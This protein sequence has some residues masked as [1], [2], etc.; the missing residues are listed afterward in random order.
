MS[1]YHGCIGQRPMGR[2]QIA[3][4]GALTLVGLAG[5][6]FR[7]IRPSYS[8]VGPVPGVGDSAGFDAALFQTTGAHLRGGHRWWL[9][10]DGQIFDAL[11]TD[12]G[13]AHDSVNFVEYIWEPGDPS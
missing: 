11:V 8:L 7:G 5:C 12:I 13:Q 2:P 3:L 6:A 4:L 10:P 9:E 1:S